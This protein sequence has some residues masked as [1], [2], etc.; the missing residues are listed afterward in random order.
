MGDARR[1]HRPPVL[2]SVI[3]LLQSDLPGGYGV[4]LL[5]T[6]LALGAVCILAWAVL[7]WSAKRGLGFGGGKRVRVLERVSLDSRR[8]LY[9]VQIGERVFLIGA[10]DAAA[11]S[12][13]AE[14]EEGELPELPEPASSFAEVLGRL[15]GKAPAEK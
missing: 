11:P 7:R 6:L 4:A 1:L 12:V 9:L 3:L 14:L 10:G 2:K 15:R 5:Q 8:A 13:L